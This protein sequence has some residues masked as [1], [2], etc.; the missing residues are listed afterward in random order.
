[1]IPGFPLMSPPSAPLPSSPVI[2][3]TEDGVRMYGEI[4]E[5]YQTHSEGRDP[6][7]GK[8]DG[9]RDGRITAAVPLRSMSLPEAA[10][11]PDGHAARGGQSRLLIPQPGDRQL[12]VAHDLDD[13]RRLGL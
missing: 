10:P 2:G 7:T 11:P 8:R 9:A 1:M 6:E 4:E 12:L 13:I 3:E 5:Q